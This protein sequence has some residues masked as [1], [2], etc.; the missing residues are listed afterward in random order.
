[1]TRSTL[2]TTVA[3]LGI[4]VLAAGAVMAHGQGRHFGYGN[5]FGPGMHAPMYGQ[6]Q[7]PGMM[8]GYGK[9]FGPGACQ[10]GAQVLDTPLTVDD[11]RAHI[12]QR[13]QWRG[14]DRLKVGEVKELDDKTIVAEIVTVDDSLVKKIQIDKATGRRTPIQ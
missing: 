5:G 9:G 8:Q 11:V 7:G 4:V 2:L 13:L 12:E 3:A 6:M 1:M 10:Q 14:N